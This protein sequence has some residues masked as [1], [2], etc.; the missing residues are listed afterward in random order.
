L[1]S[2]IVPFA[3]AAEIAQSLAE[4]IDDE[5]LRAGFLSAEPVRR[6]SIEGGTA[7]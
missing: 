1:S 6:L 4:K 3:C 2:N 7:C 5:R